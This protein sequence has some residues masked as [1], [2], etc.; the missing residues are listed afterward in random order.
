MILAEISFNSIFRG[1]LGIAFCVGLAWLVSEKRKNISWYTVG[2]GLLIQLIIAILILQVG[3]IEHIFD[4]LGKAFVKVISFTDFGISFLM[5]SFVTQKMEP[6][7]INFAF[8]VLP[9]IVFFSALSAILYYY[10]ILQ[11][12]VKIFARIMGKLMRLSGAE[13]LSA[14]AN[15]FMGQTES[16]LLIKPYLRNMTRS[17]L[18]AMMTGG[19]ATIAGSVLA[20]YIAFLGGDSSQEQVLFAK[21]LLTASVLS[22]PAAMVAA[23]I[24]V[25]ETKAIAKKAQIADEIKSANVLEAITNGTTDGLKLAINVGAMLLV[26]TALVYLG[27]YLL[28]WTGDLTGINNWIAL[29]TG[30]TELSFQFLVGYLGAPIAWMIGVPAED[31]VLVGQLLGEKTILNE[32]Y[33]YVTMGELKANGD[34]VHEKSMIMATYILCGFA[35][36]ASIGI[37]VGGIGALVPERKG[38]LSQLGLKALIAGT[39]ACLFTACLVGIFY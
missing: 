6:S 7:L 28:F 20:S 13:S 14:A 33:A 2:V 11:F 27:N 29:N 37:Q 39:L 25:P 34:F 19:M 9:K 1:L 32:F 22:A 35:N 36:I 24:I 3:W 12:F 4:W 10:G 16:P 21:H 30:Y 17:E 23:K 5:D 31:I 18:M 8:T 38:E 15:I 26:F